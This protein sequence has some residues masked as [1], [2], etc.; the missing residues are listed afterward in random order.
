M[1]IHLVGA[2]LF[3]AD[4]QTGGRTDDEANSSFAQFCEIS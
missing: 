2:N 3:H 1:K 4:E